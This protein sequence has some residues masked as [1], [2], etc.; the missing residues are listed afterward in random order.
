M[1]DLFLSTVPSHFL[2]ASAAVVFVTIFAV[3]LAIAIWVGLRY[4]HMLKHSQ[5]SES[6]LRAV[7]D[8]A[9]DAIVM[10]NAQG[11]IQSFN[12]AAEKMLGWSAEEVID[13]NVNILMPNPY[14]DEHDGYL[15][16]HLS[17]GDKRIIGKAREVT[18][19]RKDGSLLPIRLAVGRVEMPGEPLFVGFITDIS[20]RR[21]IE[22]SLLA[23]E[24][25]FRS[26]ISN[27]PGVTFRSRP[28]PDCP[29]L[30]ISDAVEQLTGWSAADFA[31]ARICMG[32]L[33]HPDDSERIW[34][35][36]SQALAHQQPYRIDY[37]LLRRD[38]EMRWV[39]ERGRGVCDASGKVQWIDGVIFDN[40]L[41]K[42][43]NAEFEGTVHAID[44]AMAV[45]EFD[46]DSRI[47]HANQNFLDLIGYTLTQIKGQ[48]HAMF[49][50]PVDVQSPAYAQFWQRLRSGY[51]EGNEYLRLGKGGREI[52]LQA[53]YNPIFDANGK[54]LKIV[55]LAT[56]LTL[57]RS[58]EQALR[59]AKE[60]AE[61]AAAARSSFVAN[62]S[63]EIRTPM[64]A[65][66]G[67]SSALLDTPL[68][69]TQRRHLNTVHHAA[70]SLLR[71]L[72]G[73]L[74]T[75]K[76]EK[77]AIDLEISHFSLRNLCRQI[78][79]SLRITAAQKNLALELDYP[80][81]VPEH[82]QGDA[83][84][85]QQIA[86]NLLG[87]AIKFT[88]VGS[89]TL[90]VGYQHRHLVLD[91]V[92]TGIGIAA[93]KL[94]RIFEPFAQADAST[95]RKFGGTGL[96][97]TI[98]R[99]LAEL[100]GGSISVHSQLGQG[101]TF[102]VRV[103]LALGEAAIA[104]AQHPLPEL[105]PL[106]VL[107]VDDVP[108]NLELLQ[109]T[110]AA[111]QH[112]ITLAH[113]GAE[114]VAACANGAFDVV[115]MDLQMPQMDGL[116]ATRHIRQHE[117]AHTPLRA[118][119][120]IIAL[121]ASVLEQDRRNARAA[122]MNGFAS[123]PLEPVRLLSEIARVLA[124]APDDSHS[125]DNTNGEGN[126]HNADSTNPLPT[127]TQLQMPIPPNTTPINWPRGLQLWG[128]P[129][130]LHHS[131]Q[132][133]LDEHHTT[134]AQLQTALAEGDWT[135]LAQHAH[136][137]RGAAGNLALHQVQALAEHSEAAAH[138]H[139]A[140]AARNAIAALPAA[141]DAVRCALGTHA[142]SSTTATAATAQPLSAQQRSAVLAALAQLSSA[143]AQGELPD[144]PLHT[145][146]S[147]LP[148][149]RLHALHEAIDRFDFSEAQRC[150][151]TLQQQ[152][153]T[154]PS[155]IPP[156]TTP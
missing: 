115:L 5:K 82:L 92:D 105:P 88:D 94:E 57:R 106:R 4:R 49:C 91:V 74:D 48:K 111:G 41:I 103:P 119:V 53:S 1:F 118:P 132:R 77:G 100:M 46:L 120:P 125:A 146:S 143:L 29:M 151:D 150:L 96:G 110:L 121:S 33:V 84:R 113:D 16:H 114:A 35:E 26:L 128:T 45:V 138:Q 101:S 64:N 60:R 63:H 126:A 19:M 28:T 80:S 6:Q 52:W 79:A 76:L 134:P 10:I 136:R 47:L 37:R 75:A 156:S 12:G 65:I 112:H 98:S 18:A 20:Q 70:H 139:D 148:V 116:E 38:G 69:A 154:P 2:T 147:H 8:T 72:N 155:T 131:V 71:L 152:L 127:P 55:K 14:K 25:R 62:I 145:L 11:R 99:Q 30:F 36:V 122:G 135:A 130:R 54:L 43:R 107:A 109:I 78:L 108:D 31:D 59:A 117:Q 129:E 51:M 21:A 81:S 123:K 7:V 153:S 27:L 149:Q 22:E 58:M 97:T 40:T 90:R 34:Q 17:T 24:E 85:L 67:F 23:S 133:F 50:C 73:V 44:R 39:S 141:L 3:L 86:L 61:E 83:F 140:S 104:Q 9:I 32:A 42:T 56:D 95:T 68:D 15:H 13:H 93:D 144:A 124:N 87:N 142:S 89:V 102:S 66:L 137:M